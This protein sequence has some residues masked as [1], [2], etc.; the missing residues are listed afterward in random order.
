MKTSGKHRIL[1]Y[2]LPLISLDLV[3]QLI[4]RRRQKIKSLEIILTLYQLIECDTRKIKH[5]KCKL[6]CDLIHMI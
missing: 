1:I 6:R 3:N 5:S 4:M 2:C